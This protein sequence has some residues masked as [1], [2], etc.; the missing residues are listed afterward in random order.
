VSSLSSRGTSRGSVTGVKALAKRLLFPGVDVHARSRYRHIAPRLTPKVRTLDAGCG[1]GMLTWAAYQ[2]RCDVVGVTNDE[3]EH[4]RNVSFYY[5]RRD[6]HA[7]S[8]FKFMVHD[9]RTPLRGTFDQVIC[10]E[11]LEHIYDD[12]LVVK[13]L[14]SVMPAGGVLHVCVPNAEHPFHALDRE[15]EPEDGRH[16]RDGYTVESLTALLSPD[17]EMVETVG[18]GTPALVRVDH[19]VRGARER[20][21]HAVAI[22]LLLAVLPFLGR[23]DRVN[24]AV[25]FSLYM[26]ARRV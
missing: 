15:D 22:P 21:G 14:A 25:P 2:L 19:V 3:D 1:N 8:Q 4:Y 20:I 10:S 5:E 18:I 12:E 9:L 24:P 13:N 7:E 17:F 23:I 16:V 26:Q 6:F 11:V